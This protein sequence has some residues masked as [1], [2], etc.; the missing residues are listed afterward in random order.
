MRSWTLAL[1]I[2]N[3]AMIYVSTCSTL[4]KSSSLL[5]ILG[6]AMGTVLLREQKKLVGTTVTASADGRGANYGVQLTAI[7]HCLPQALFAW[8]MLLLA[9]Q[10]FW[11]AFA[12]LPLPLSLATFLLVVAMLVTAFVGIRKVVYP[13]QEVF[14]GPAPPESALPTPIPL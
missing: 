5:C 14:K 10:G 9:I 12:D 4:I 1:L 7:A 8:A 13:H 3:I 2:L 11:I 6:L